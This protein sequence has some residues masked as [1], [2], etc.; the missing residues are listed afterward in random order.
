VNKVVNGVRHAVTS[1]SSGF[2]NPVG[3][4]ND[5]KVVKV[6]AGVFDVYTNGNKFSEVT[7]STFSNGP[8]GTI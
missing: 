4:I 8:A 6:A 7:D 1:G 5:L 3:T 2:V